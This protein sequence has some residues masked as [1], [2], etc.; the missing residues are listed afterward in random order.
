[1][2]FRIERLS[3]IMYY[4]DVRTNHILSVVCHLSAIKVKITY[5]LYFVFDILNFMLYI[6]YSPFLAYISYFNYTDYMLDVLC[7]TV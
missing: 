4:H 7:Y 3:L 2:I 1:M 5:I 6:F